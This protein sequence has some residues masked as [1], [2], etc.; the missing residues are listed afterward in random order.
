MT[1]TIKNLVALG[2]G[3]ALAALFGLQATA[4]AKRSS[5]V[6]KWIDA[7]REELRSASQA[8]GVPSSVLAA[9]CL[10][11]GGWRLTQA[12]WCGQT[13]TAPPTPAKCPHGEP[14][15][16]GGKGPCMKQFDSFH[17]AAVAV[18][19]NLCTNS[20]YAAGRSVMSAAGGDIKAFDHVKFF[21]AIAKPYCC[22]GWEAGTINMLNVHDLKNLDDDEEPVSCTSP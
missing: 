7:H 11:E 6:Q 21:T 12:N 15:S 3:L 20:R 9:I 17:D 16:D 10:R 18:G 14:R 8:T 2:L 1:K 4:L 13:V 22:A 19:E 5:D